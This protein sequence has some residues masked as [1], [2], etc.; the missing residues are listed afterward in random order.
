MLTTHYRSGLYDFLFF[1]AFSQQP[2]IVTLADH[3]GRSSTKTISL[4]PLTL[5][6][7][8]AAK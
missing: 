6:A 3:F 8:T 5:A 4:P 2:A 7:A 1:E